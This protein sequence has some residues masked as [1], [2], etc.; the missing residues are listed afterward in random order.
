ML[1]QKYDIIVIGAGHAGLEAAA[2]AARMGCRTLMVTLDLSKIAELSC[3]P[4]I[5]GI[6]KGQLVREVAALGGLMG[7]VADEACIQFRMLNTNRGAAVRSTRMQVDSQHYRR[8]A[9][10]RLSR[11]PH[12]KLLEDEVQ[13]LIIDQGAVCGVRLK[14]NGTVT[15][16]IV[17]LAPGTFFHGLIH[18]G[19]KHFPGGRWQDQ[20]SELLPQQLMDL[21]LKFGRFKTGTTPRLDQK[22]IDF[23]RL[24]EQS[25][26]AD[27]RPFSRQSS[28]G[29]QLDQVSCFIG[30]TNAKTHRII[31]NNLKR[32]ALYSGRI[33]GTGVRY[34]PSVEDKVVKFPDRESHHVFLEPEGLHTEWWYPNGISNSLPLDV[35]ETMVR[36]IAGLEKAV[37]V[38]TGYGIEH[39]YIDPTQLEPSLQSKLIKGLFLAGQINGTTGYEEAAAQGLMAGINAARSIQAEEA[40]ILDRSQAYIGVLIDDLVTKGTTEPYRMF[41]SRV[42]YRLVIREDNADERLAPLGRSLGLVNDK[43][44]ALFADEE[45]AI[46]Q[47]Q[48]R[49]KNIRIYPGLK[50]ES[51]LRE[52]SAP[53]LTKSIT[54]KE[55]LRRPEVGY[56][57]LG[58]L[59]PDAAKIPKNVS[60]R[61]AIKVKYEGYIRRQNQEIEKFKH[62]EKMRIPPEFEYQGLPG[63]SLEIVEKLSCLRPRN[64]GQA[65]RISGVT[66]A[67]ITL[68]MLYIKKSGSKF[69]AKETN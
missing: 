35:Q 46:Q 22:S 5:G 26:D 58:R 6:G 30:R 14:K 23:S 63:L 13:D 44:Y 48:V 50:S 9:Q 36:S 34:C 45:K 68:L 59:D 62:L 39:D 38:Q 24:I 69:C 61:V 53:P 55:L 43:D 33:T 10:S 2:A 51:I 54:L 28:E 32:S 25:G 56:A 52:K 20:N 7:E 47:E 29:F 17:V 31:R 11:I 21:G 66:P 40:V 18:I 60:D 19:M 8:A 41:T 49:L 3:N 16:S 67:A 42:E 15:C 12:L 37:I 65:G 64:L 1:N 27:F 57:E 4:A